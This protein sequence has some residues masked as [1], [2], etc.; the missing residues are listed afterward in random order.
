MV[1][2][3]PVF[4]RTSGRKRYGKQKTTA[5]AKY[6]GFECSS[7]FY[8]GRGLWEDKRGFLQ[9]C[10][11]LLAGGAPSAKCAA[12]PNALGYFLFP[13]AWH[14]EPCRNPLC[15][16]PPFLNSWSNALAAQ[17]IASQNR[18]D[19]RWLQAGSRTNRKVFSLRRPQKIASPLA[20][21]GVTL[22]IAGSL[23][24]TTAA[25]RRNRAI[26]RPAATTGH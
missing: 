26:S 25:S 14:W 13:S 19:P 1:C 6:F 23:Q 5:I 8:Y 22:K 7:C 12:G 15:E 9:T 11:P 2:E 16:K 18:S 4:L 24:R 17:T 10:T 3:S 20:I 21:F